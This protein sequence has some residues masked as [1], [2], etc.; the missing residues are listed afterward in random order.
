MKLL[1]FA[2]ALCAAPA[3]AFAGDHSPA[4]PHEPTIV[5]RYIARSSGKTTCCKK[6][7]TGVPC[8]NTCISERKTCRSGPGC[9]C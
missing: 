8:G 2:L 5:D 4:Q 7:T 3:F 6:C 1:A 9:A